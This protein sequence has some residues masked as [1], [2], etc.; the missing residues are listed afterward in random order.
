VIGAA[1]ALAAILAGASPS[2]A[3]DAPAALVKG[4]VLTAEV[5]DDPWGG[6]GAAGSLVIADKAGQTAEYSVDGTTRVTRDGKKIKFDKTLVGDA[7]VRATYD[8]QT[9][10]LTLLDLQSPSGEKAAKKAAKAEAAFVTGEVAFADAIKGTLSVRQGSGKTR[11]FAVSDATKVLR[12][13]A[14]GQAQEIGFESVSI[15]DPV[16]V[17]SRDGKTADTIRIRPAAK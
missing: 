16:E 13:K 5:A 10:V 2:R 6:P 3:A 14:E 11:D 8:P 15:G 12:S 4:R 9:K 1:A 17:R 7:V